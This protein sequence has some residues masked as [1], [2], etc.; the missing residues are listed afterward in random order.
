MADLHRFE[1]AERTKGGFQQ[2]AYRLVECQ[3]SLFDQL[4]RCR[5]RDDRLRERCHVEECLRPYGAGVIIETRSPERAERSY[6]ATQSDS[7]RSGRKQAGFK[8]LIEQCIGSIETHCRPLIL[9]DI[10]LDWV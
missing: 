5:C 9:L 3:P 8:A 6:F 2:L 7:K 10:T 4:E 1:M